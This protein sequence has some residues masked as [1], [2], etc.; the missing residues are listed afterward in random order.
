MFQPKIIF[1][2][3]DHTLYIP[4]EKRIPESAI[5]A[6]NR[7]NQK[8]IITAIATGRTLAALPTPIRVLIDQGL[9]KTVVSINGQYTQHNGTPL[10]GFPMTHHAVQ[11]IAQQLHHKAIAHAF[12]SEQGIFTPLSNPYL[13]AAVASVGITSAQ[14]CGSKLPENV[15]QILAFYP[16]SK[17]AEIAT[18][19]PEDM[20]TVRWHEFGV[21]IL[22]DEA[23]KA[24]GIQAV[25]DTLNLTMHD[26]MAFGDGLND[27]EMI[28]SVGCGVAMS[29]GE[30]AL[31]A[32][33]QH[34]CPAAEEDGIYRFLSE[35]SII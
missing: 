30:A 34:I 11:H 6:L 18:M 9:I 10:I 14:T 27:M 29:N 33:A 32:I 16:E 20:K 12:V 4:S 13:E 25:L 22:P 35:N 24:R 5:A 26:T 1:F 21:D 19:L 31:K 23:S 15:F 8:G 3:I 2:D 28:A 7:L 17:D